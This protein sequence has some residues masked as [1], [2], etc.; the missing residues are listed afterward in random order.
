MPVL[1]VSI[2]TS[3]LLFGLMSVFPSTIAAEGDGGRS[4]FNATLLRQMASRGAKISTTAAYD[5]N[6]VRA[7]FTSAA[8]HASLN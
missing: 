4:E 6:I 5:S 8:D 1:I 3:V 2:I 7:G